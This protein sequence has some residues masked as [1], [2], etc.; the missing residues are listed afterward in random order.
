MELMDMQ[1]QRF[2]GT[3]SLAAAVGRSPITVER[4]LRTKAISPDAVLV[5]PSGRE[6]ALFKEEIFDVLMDKTP[7]TC[8]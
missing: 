7:D 8:L 2:F 6:L 5:T 1:H 3:A 4:A